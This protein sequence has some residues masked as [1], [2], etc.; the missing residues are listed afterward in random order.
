MYQEKTEPIIDYYKKKNVLKIVNGDDTV[1]N[2]FASI[3]KII[4]E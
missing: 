4:N 2:I 1:D 3:D